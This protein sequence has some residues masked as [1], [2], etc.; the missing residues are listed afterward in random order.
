MGVA[1][2][3]MSDILRLVVLVLFP[4]ITLWLTRIG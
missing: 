3:C 1:G 4:Q 2:F